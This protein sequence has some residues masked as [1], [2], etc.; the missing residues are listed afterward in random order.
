MFS[1]FDE[2]V[3]NDEIEELEVRYLEQ[4]NFDLANIDDCDDIICIVF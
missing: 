1:V 2:G 3:S 4:F